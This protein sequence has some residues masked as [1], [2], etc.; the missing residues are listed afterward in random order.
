ME[1][2]EGG[3]GS[4]S[5]PIVTE[6]YQASKLWNSVNLKIQHL[7][8]NWILKPK[9]FLISIRPH[10]TI[11]QRNTT[12]HKLSHTSASKLITWDLGLFW[13]H[14]PHWHDYVDLCTPPL[15]SKVILGLF[16]GVYCM[17]KNRQGNTVP[18]QQKLIWVFGADISSKTCTNLTVWFGAVN[19][20][21]S[22]KISRAHILGST[23]RLLQWNRVVVLHAIKPNSKTIFFWP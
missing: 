9:K 13:S 2:G 3:Q 12:A 4:N 6:K 20:G 7:Y 16:I 11:R 5:P 10:Q 14:D 22:L 15:S 17:Q 1:G 19:F 23:Y 8:T 18:T 21:T